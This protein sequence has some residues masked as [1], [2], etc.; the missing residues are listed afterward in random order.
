LIDNGLNSVR[1]FS[2][3]AIGEDFVGL[4]GRLARK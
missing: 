2:W 1:Q 3:D 4:C